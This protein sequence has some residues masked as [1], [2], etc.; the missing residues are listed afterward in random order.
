MSSFPFYYVIPF[1]V[2]NAVGE[3]QGPWRLIQISSNSCH[4]A[5]VAS[6]G[7]I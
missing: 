2:A 4:S 1:D 7:E 3:I 5:V 6:K